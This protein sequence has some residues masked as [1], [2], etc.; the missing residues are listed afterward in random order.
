MGTNAGDTGG[1]SLLG[2][3]TALGSGRLTL[4]HVLCDDVDGLL[5]GDHG[6]EPHQLVMLEGLHEVRFFQ[7]SLHRHRAWFQRFH[8][9]FGAIVIVT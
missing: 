4:G 8:S 5:L 3:V 2:D 7:E 9:H 1:L 6:V